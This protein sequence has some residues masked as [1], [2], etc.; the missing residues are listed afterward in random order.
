MPKSENKKD[1]GQVLKM[2]KIVS[3]QKYKRLQRLKNLKKILII[4]TV[5][6]VLLYIVFSLVIVGI[7]SVYGWR[8]AFYIAGIPGLILAALF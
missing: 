8:E 6:C 4:G 3:L 5:F 1:L 7:G 2:E